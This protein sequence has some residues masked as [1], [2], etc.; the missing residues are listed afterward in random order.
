MDKESYL[1]NLKELFGRK[2]KETTYSDAEIK[3]IKRKV[4]SEN[5]ISRIPPQV[6]KELEKRNFPTD[7]GIKERKAS[8]KKEIEL[9]HHMPDLIKIVQNQLYHL[10]GDGG[11]NSW[12]Y[13]IKDGS[14]WWYE[15]DE[16]NENKR[17]S[18]IANNVREWS[19]ILDRQGWK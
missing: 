12:W 8:Y 3:K 14:I 10:A 7:Y 9:M 5:M 1:Q 18:K 4:P 6:W 13:S 2:E 15:H 17:F 19:K 16:W 11:G